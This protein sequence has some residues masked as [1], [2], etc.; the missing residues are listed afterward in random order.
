MFLGNKYHM[1]VEWIASWMSY[2]PIIFTNYLLIFIPFYTNMWELT[3]HQNIGEHEFVPSIWDSRET[4]MT[5][6]SNGRRVAPSANMSITSICTHR[7]YIKDSDRNFHPLHYLNYDFWK[8]RPVIRFGLSQRVLRQVTDLLVWVTVT[9]ERQ[10][11][12]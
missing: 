3:L 10:K 5:A 4:P 6:I 2:L 11:T 8:L 9:P 12:N 1:H 7:S